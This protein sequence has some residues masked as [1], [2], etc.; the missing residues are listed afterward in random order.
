ME[1]MNQNEVI[2]FLRTVNGN[3][4]LTAMLTCSIILILVRNF[5]IFL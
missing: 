3:E 4:N 1:W 5:M 2:L